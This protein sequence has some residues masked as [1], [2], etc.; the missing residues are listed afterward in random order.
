MLRNRRVRLAIVL[1]LAI[2]AA[3]VAWRTQGLPRRPCTPGRNAEVDASGKVVRVV[4]TIC[5]DG[6]AEG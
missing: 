5:T 1:A 4:R 6:S 3:F 2:V